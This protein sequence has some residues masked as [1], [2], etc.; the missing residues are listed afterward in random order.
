M[1]VV[2]APWRLE[3]IHGKRERGCIFCN[4]VRRRTDRKDFILHRAKRSFV[5]LNKYPYNNGHLMVVPNRH[6]AGLED[7]S[8]DE[9]LEIFDLLGRA[10]KALKRG[11]RAQG[12]N[13]GLNLGRAAG[14]GIRDHIHFH[15]VPRW[16]GDTNFWPV[17]AE[18]RTMPEHL[19]S[20]YRRLQAAWR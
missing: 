20:T 3:F 17:L 19:T 4:R 7:L 5:I 2:W 11:L 12:L 15:I 13:F 1:K 6:V 8:S 16:F 14:A 10:S 18:T 9:A